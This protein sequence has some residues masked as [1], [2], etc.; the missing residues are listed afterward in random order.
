MNEQNPLNTVT[1]L[2]EFGLGIAVA[3]QM[4]NTINHCIDNM[5]TPGADSR[6]Q[7]S[8]NQNLFH[9]VSNNNVTGPFTLDEITVLIRAKTIT[10]ETLAW[11]YGLSGWTKA[12]NIPE[13]NK[14]IM[15]NPNL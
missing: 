4:V 1:D 15:L 8:Y 11:R 3:Q 12:G 14:L 10:V 2:V 7:N 6:I 13:I 9:I 5:K